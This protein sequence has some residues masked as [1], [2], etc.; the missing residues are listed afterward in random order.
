MF[1]SNYSGCFLTIRAFQHLKTS[2]KM[3]PKY[4]SYTM[5]INGCKTKSVAQDIL[6]PLSVFSLCQLLLRNLITACVGEGVWGETGGNSQWESKR[7]SKCG[8]CY[9]QTKQSAA[10]FW[11][12]HLLAWEEDHSRLLA[13]GEERNLSWVRKSLAEQEPPLEFQRQMLSLAQA[14]SKKGGGNL[15]WVLHPTAAVCIKKPGQLHSIR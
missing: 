3:N 5:K 6:K 8:A 9:L 1:L 12:G 14:L 13:Y 2:A 11:K 15:L 7:R 10:A 4:Q